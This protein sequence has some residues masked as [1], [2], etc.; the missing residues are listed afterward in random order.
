MFLAGNK[1]FFAVLFVNNCEY[2]T[3]FNCMR[4]RHNLNMHP[5]DRYLIETTT[6]QGCENLV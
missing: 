4:M 5:R 1:D 3:V 6:G 2:N